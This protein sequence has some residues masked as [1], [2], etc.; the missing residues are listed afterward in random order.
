M[1]ELYH[2]LGARYILTE[3]KPIFPIYTRAMGYTYIVTLS[4]KIFG[5]SEFAGRLPSLIFMLTFLATSGY[6]VRRFFGTFPALLFLLV[7]AL[8]PLS[9]ELVRFCLIYTA[10]AF[11]ISLQRGP[12]PARNYGAGFSKNEFIQNLKIN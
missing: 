6:F 11:F 12:C 4:Y 8:S 10:F 9:I 5:I 2:A 7:L 3:G 1:G